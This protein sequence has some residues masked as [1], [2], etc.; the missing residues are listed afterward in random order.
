MKSLNVADLALVLQYKVP[1]RAFLALLDSGSNID[2]DEEFDWY[3]LSIGYFL[4]LGVARNDAC[5]LA[6]IVRYQ[7]DHVREALPR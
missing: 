5:D 3:S 6:R 1:V 2:P 7:E 4:G